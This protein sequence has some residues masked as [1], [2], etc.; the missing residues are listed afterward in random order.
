MSTKEENS[1]KGSK[2]SDNDGEDKDQAGGQEKE[3]KELSEEKT[4]NQVF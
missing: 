1:S 4:T 3:K 2:E